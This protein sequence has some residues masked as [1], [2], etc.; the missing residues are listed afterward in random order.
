MEIEE[1]AICRIYVAI[2]F[3]NWAVINMLSLLISRVKPIELS[4]QVLR[5]YS[6]VEVM[7]Q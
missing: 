2:F 6:V 5:S 3:P 7:I 4:P 1:R